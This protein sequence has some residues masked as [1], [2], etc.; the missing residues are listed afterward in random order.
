MS[1][2]VPSFLNE[3]LKRVT[4]L[5]ERVA[6]FKQ[7]SEALQLVVDEL[8]REKALQAEQ[9]EKWKLALFDWKAIAESRP[10]MTDAAVQTESQETNDCSVE[11]AALVVTINA[12]CATLSQ[13]AEGNSLGAL[14]HSAA[15]LFEEQS[16]VLR[17][18]ERQQGELESA[19]AATRHELSLRASEAEDK[20]LALE[21]AE[22]EAAAATE[23]VTML[24]Q[25][26]DAVSAELAIRSAAL[27]DLRKSAVDESVLRDLTDAKAALELRN[28]SLEE[29][30]REA[31]LRAEE[32]ESAVRKALEDNERLTDSLRRAE[33][34]AAN[35][36]RA[37]EVAATTEAMTE[38]AAD[39]TMQ[40]SRPAETLRVLT[41]Q[42]VTAVEVYE[43]S[44]SSDDESDVHQPSCVIPPLR[45]A[46]TS[47]R[48]DVWKRNPFLRDLLAS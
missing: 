42:A 34:R 9:L 6:A 14:V 33:E 17:D 30:R 16:L 15:K 1:A 10:E 25:E 31:V 8:T 24:E 47:R 36:E 5:R 7:K 12:A 27:E 11:M 32:A 40:S 46:S 41:K 20:S 38:W 45:L 28:E 26:A 23:R 4:H 2:P 43:L 29:A 35:A 48:E 18:H 21:E 13:F 37:A 39:E 19:L 22:A 3:H 44:S